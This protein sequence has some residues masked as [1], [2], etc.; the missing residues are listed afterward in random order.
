MAILNS[1]DDLKK[2]DPAVTRLVDSDYSQSDFANQRAEAVAWLQ[3]TI[4]VHNPQGIDQSEEDRS[5]GYLLE[6]D[7]LERAAAYYCLYLIYRSAVRT[8]GDERDLKANHWLARAY[9][10]LN[11]AVVEFDTDGD[12]DTNYQ[13]AIASPRIG[14]G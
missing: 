11:T 6:T 3:R 2:Y 9:Q 10:A 7:E 12:G 14:R 4:D 13:F 1:D 8:P 5:D